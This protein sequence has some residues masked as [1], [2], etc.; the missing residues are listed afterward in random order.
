M[1]V[2]I[3]ARFAAVRAGAGEGL[4]AGRDGGDLLRDLALGI[5]AI[6]I[7]RAGEGAS[8][9]PVAIPATGGFGR[10]EM[11]PYSDLDLLFLC[12]GLPDDRARALAD[13]VLYPLWDA[14]VDA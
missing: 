9:Q 4:R 11:A 7:G 14:R 1:A 3:A 6:L 5:V 8:G 13:A 2:S 12:P 10:R